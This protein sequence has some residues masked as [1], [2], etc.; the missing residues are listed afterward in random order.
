MPLRK[1][2]KQNPFFSKFTNLVYRTLI[3]ELLLRR[4]LLNAQYLQQEAVA[5]D[6]YFEL[7]LL[8]L[9]SSSE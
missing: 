3:L 6:A 5:L 1:I 7:K 9:Y 8:V 2:K 4:T